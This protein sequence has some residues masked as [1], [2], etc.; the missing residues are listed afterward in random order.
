MSGSPSSIPQP[1]EEGTLELSDGRSLGYAEYGP[2]DGDPLFFFHGTPGSRYTR[3]PETSVLHEHGIRQVTLERPGFGRSTFDPDRELLDWPADVCE[4]ADALGWERFAVFGGSGG[5]PFVLACAARIPERLTRVG[6]VGGMGPLDA[7]GATDGMELRNRIGFTLAK[8]PLLLRPFLWLRIRK[9]RKDTDGFIDAWA[10][11]AA[12]PDQRILQRPGVRAVFKQNFPE[13]V[14]QGTRGPLH[15]TRLLASAWGFDP[16]DST[17][18]VD[19]YHGSRDAFTPESMVRYVADR[20]P[21]CTVHLYPEEG[22]LLHYEHWAEILS[23]LYR[24]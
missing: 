10:D 3:V 9:I 2:S 19:L 22:H 15:E 13:A 20:I 18:H 7:P 5:G 17:I 12:A 6:V 21:S 8:V 1:A 11:S 24:E 4:A 16:V 14:R 23:T